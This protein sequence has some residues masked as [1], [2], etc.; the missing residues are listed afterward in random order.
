MDGPRTGFGHTGGHTVDDVDVCLVGTRRAITDA[1]EV[2]RL[3]RRE[4]REAQEGV[5]HRLRGQPGRAL[6]SGPRG[7]RFKS[8]RP[9]PRFL[10]KPAGFRPL[11]HS[12][13]I[14]WFGASNKPLALF[15][16]P[17]ALGVLLP[18]R[19]LVD[20]VSW[21][22]TPRRRPLL[23]FTRK[24]STTPGRRPAVR[25]ALRWS[26]NKTRTISELGPAY[27]VSSDSLEHKVGAAWS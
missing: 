16:A 2:L 25:M 8:S 19:T 21:A 22:E 11:V 14:E 15:L 5:R 1:S 20:I 3:G 17:E 27:G 13:S 7:R 23:R 4:E 10:I 18:R 26:P 12:V 9:R 24:P 6:G